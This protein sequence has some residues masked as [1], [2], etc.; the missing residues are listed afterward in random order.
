MTE[1]ASEDQCIEWSIAKKKVS[2]SADNKE[3]VYSEADPQLTAT[4]EGNAEGETLVY[5]LSRAEG[6]DAGSYNI[7]PVYDS[8]AAVNANYDI[9]CTV[10]LFTINKA[11]VTVPTAEKDLVYNGTEQTGVKLPD[12]AVYTLTGNTATK[13]GEYTATAVLKDKKNYVWDTDNPDAE[14]LTIEWSIAKANVTVPTAEKDLVY[15]GTEQTGV[16]LPDDAVYTLTGNTATKAGDYTATAAIKAENKDNYEWNVTEDASADQTIKWSIAKKSLADGT[17]SIDSIETQEFTGSE[18]KPAVTV[19]D[20]EEALTAD[21][22]YTV[23]YSNNTNV[24]TATVTVTAAENGNYQSSKNAAFTIESKAVEDVESLIAAIGTVV[25][26]DE[27]EKKILEAEAAYDA[28]TASQKNI[29]SEDK[30]N[31]LKDA[32]TQFDNLDEQAKK[33]NAIIQKTDAIAGMEKAFVYVGGMEAG[34]KFFVMISKDGKDI[35][36]TDADITEEGWVTVELSAGAL[37]QTDVTYTA[38]L[39]KMTTA[40]KSALVKELDFEAAAPAQID[41]IE[42]LIGA[43]EFDARISGVADG[44]SYNLVVEN[45]NGET[46]GYN[47]GTFSEDGTVKVYMSQGTTLEKYVR[48]ELVLNVYCVESGSQT[49]EAGRY[50]FMLTDVNEVQELIDAIGDVEYTD[51]CKARIDAAR[52]A[53]NGLSA[54]D[55]ALVDEDKLEA[56]EEAE[57]L[58]AQLKKNAEDAADATAVVEKIMAIGEVEYTDECKARIDAAREAYDALTED[59]QVLIVMETYKILTDAEKEYEALI[60]GE[61]GYEILEGKNAVWQTG[62]NEPLRFRGEGDFNKFVE[63]QIDEMTV[64]REYYSLSSGS[65]VAEISA[66]YLSTLAGGVHTLKMVWEDGTAKTQFT[67]EKAKD[68]P[69]QPTTKGD[70]QK[71]PKTGDDSNMIL[72]ILMA[73]AALAAASAAV[74]CLKRKTDR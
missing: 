34:E 4:V 7:T 50:P 67:I 28:L 20:G 71:S 42:A 44:H 68:D 24:G 46:V 74:L 32:R 51:E 55:K 2:V 60:P 5:S 73:A 52:A 56:L 36:S 63:L 39:Y 37:L 45:E 49:M 17:I 29:V 48:F 69:T 9:S 53:Y 13:A 72:W 58:Y 70:D 19:K 66:S 16:K 15:N 23:S 6:E 3:K 64:A 31:T 47:N 8:E 21:A 1:A 25:Y 11:K 14:D 27:C 26:T 61:D 30:L 59:Q 40:S 57:A 65:T 43:S 62:S 35:A 18:I 22:D 54:D 38:G 41:G 12:D 10:G 33:T